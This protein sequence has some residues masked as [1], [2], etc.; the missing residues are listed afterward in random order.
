[1]AIELEP[2]KADAYYS[3]AQAYNDKGEYAKAITDYS[4]TIELS[5]RYTMAY[6]GRSIAYRRTGESAKAAADE[7]TWLKLR[8]K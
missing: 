8:G 6:R 4:K 7:K 5:P 3:R 2:Q 1:M